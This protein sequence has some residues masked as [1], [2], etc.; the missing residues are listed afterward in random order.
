MVNKNKNNKHTRNQ[1]IFENQP[2]ES[3]FFD[4]RIWK[5]RDGR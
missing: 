3:Q 2:S 1:K 5:L 4:R